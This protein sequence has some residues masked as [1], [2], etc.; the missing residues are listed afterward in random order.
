MHTRTGRRNPKEDTAMPRKI[1]IKNCGEC[2]YVDE[3]F[4]K[5]FCLKESRTIVEIVESATGIVRGIDL[6]QYAIPN[7][8][9]L[10]KDG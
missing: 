1:V 3:R 2:P 10:E 8:C 5:A 6:E 7:W 4:H 9:G